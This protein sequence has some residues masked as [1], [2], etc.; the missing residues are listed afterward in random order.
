MP[1]I[2]DFSKSIVP[3]KYTNIH[4]KGW[5]KVTI[6]YT[7][8][9]ANQYDTLSSVCWRIKGTTHTFT[10][11]EEKINHLCEGKGYEKHFEKVLELFRSEY[12]DWLTKPEYKGCEWVKEYV[13]QYDDLIER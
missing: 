5:K 6:E 9:Q 1:F 12:L 13:N 7:V 3:V 11:Y 8:G 2:Y 4:P 10:I